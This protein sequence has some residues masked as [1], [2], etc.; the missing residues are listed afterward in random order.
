MTNKEKMMAFSAIQ[1]YLWKIQDLPVAF[2]PE[3]ADKLMAKASEL[4]GF[5]VLKPTQEQDDSIIADLQDL[6]V[7]L[8]EELLGGE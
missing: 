6:V 3:E 2:T 8:K 1:I 4:Y 5:D 7:K